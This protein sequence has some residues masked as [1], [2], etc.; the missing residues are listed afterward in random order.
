MPRASLPDPYPAAGLRSKDAASI[1][2]THLACKRARESARQSAVMKVIQPWPEVDI[3]FLKEVYRIRLTARTNAIYY[4]RQLRTVTI[5]SFWLSLVIALTASGSGLGTLLDPSQP[6]LHSIW[7]AFA[8]TAA[9]SA[10]VRPIYA[11][12]KRIERFTRQCRGYQ[13]NF[14]SLN[15]LA[16]SL[17]VTGQVTRE[18]RQRFKT[19]FERY[20]SLESSDDC[21]ASR[22]GLS[23]AQKRALHEFPDDGLWWP[24][25]VGS[26]VDSGSRQ[27]EKA[28]TI[29][30]LRPPRV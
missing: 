13:A 1:A 21:G 23:I 16:V 25:Y 12:A 4:E 2:T 14:N 19:L 5:A 10:V 15:F 27:H 26:S 3:L 22:R 28:A 11:P 29:L 8:V 20:A 18:H 30:A 17:K 24:P 6:L 9:I 7:K